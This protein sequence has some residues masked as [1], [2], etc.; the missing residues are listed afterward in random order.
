MERLVSEEGA[1]CVNLTDGDAQLVK[2][3]HGIE[4]GCNAQ[5]V[6]MPFHAVDT[7]SGGLLTTAADAATTADDYGQLMR[8]MEQAENKA[9][10]LVLEQAIKNATPLLEVKP[11]RVGGATYQVPVEVAT[12]RGQAL[13]I[14]WILKSA[15][16]RTGKSMAEKLATELGDAARGTGSTIKK[17]EDTHKM[18]EAN[19]AFAHYRW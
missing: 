1:V 5:A 18:A 10:V 15:R 7:E 8:M 11:R 4:A 19:R 9:G 13:A 14:R 2:G 6:F 12:G 17:R 3:R 16:A